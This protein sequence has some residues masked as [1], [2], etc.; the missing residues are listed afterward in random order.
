M[1]KTLKQYED[2]IKTDGLNDYQI[3]RAYRQAWEEYKEK[4]F[5]AEIASLSAIGEL[6]RYQKYLDDFLHDNKKAK[7]RGM[8]SAEDEVKRKLALYNKAFLDI[9]NNNHSTESEKK[10]LQS[11]INFLWQSCGFQRPLSLNLQQRQ[12]KQVK[13]YLDNAWHNVDK[14]IVLVNKNNNCVSVEQLLDKISQVRDKQ[15]LTKNL[16]DLLHALIIKD[17]QTLEQLLKERAIFDYIYQE[18]MVWQVAIL[19]GT[20]DELLN[21]IDIKIQPGRVTNVYKATFPHRNFDIVFENESGD[22]RT[23][24]IKE[25]FAEHFKNTFLV[26]SANNNVSAIQWIL[27]NSEQHIIAT[28]D[29]NRMTALHWA[30][31]YGN[32]EMLHCLLARGADIAIQDRHGMSVLDHAVVNGQLEAASIL[33]QALK[34]QVDNDQLKLMLSRALLM[35]VKQGNSAIIS[36]LLKEGASL[37][38]REKIEKPVSGSVSA[39]DWI[40]ANDDLA[41]LQCVWEAARVNTNYLVHLAALYGSTKIMT[42]L[43]QNA[44]DVHQVYGLSGSSALHVAAEHGNIDLVRFLV[45]KG[46]ATDAYDG[47]QTTPLSLAT[48][49][50]HTEVAEYLLSLKDNKKVDIKKQISGNQTPLAQVA[51]FDDAQQVQSRYKLFKAMLDSEDE[52]I[53]GDDYIQN[54]ELQPVNEQQKQ[55]IKSL[56]NCLLNDAMGYLNNVKHPEL[57]KNATDMMKVISDLQ[58]SKIPLKFSMGIYLLA[59]EFAKEYLEDAAKVNHIVRCETLIQHY[60]KLIAPSHSEK[61]YMGLLTIAGLALGMVLG[62]AAII[63]VGIMLGAWASPLLAVSGV[64]ALVTGGVT[65]VSATAAGVLAGGTALAGSVGAWVTHRSCFW[66]SK[67]QLANV[68]RE[69]LAKK[70]VLWELSLALD[71]AR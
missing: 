13:L 62:A 52:F 39:L 35:A 24:A 57:G 56:Q 12:D 68:A 17:Y 14:N 50:G 60:M 41:L 47:R 26:A 9:K 10:A 31:A 1:P 34:N 71:L 43:V 51:L 4:D 8:V 25:L 55:N 54:F 44:C 69:Q 19:T 48:A 27:N 33:I 38:Y 59:K 53:L 28:V 30:A 36:L 61:F 22:L 67:Y 18:A 45:E 32:N 29:P 16:S 42:Y 40:F 11:Y 7:Y 20:A 58:R 3:E 21:R 23:R 2:E 6:E 46:V 5:A 49:K 15:P 37:D 63:G 66:S 64:T 70:E 65:E